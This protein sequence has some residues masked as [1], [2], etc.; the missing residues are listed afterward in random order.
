MMQQCM[1]HRDL[2]LP[3]PAGIPLP[4]LMLVPQHDECTPCSARLCKTLHML[5]LSAGC[6]RMV[7]SMETSDM[8]HGCPSSTTFMAYCHR[9][10]EQ[11]RADHA[12]QQNTQTGSIPERQ[13]RANQRPKQHRETSRDLAQSNAPFAKTDSA[14][15]PACSTMR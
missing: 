14:G 5:A 15:M 1:P 11:S 12:C 9:S 2:P 8:R 10:T 13:K 6:N 7:L 4:R 3:F